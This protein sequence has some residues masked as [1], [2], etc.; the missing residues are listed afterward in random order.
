LGTRTLSK[1]VS[2]KPCWPAMLISGRTEM[3]G[4]FMS[5]RKK[6]MPRCLGA[7]GSVRASMKIQSAR[8]A[9]LVQIF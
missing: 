5:T 6:E 9:L 1:K 2:L 7:S 8:W 3:P 4:D